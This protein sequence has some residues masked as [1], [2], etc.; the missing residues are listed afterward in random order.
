MEAGPLGFYGYPDDPLLQDLYHL[1]PGS[2]KSREAT[3]VA[4]RLWTERQKPT[5]YLMLTHEAI[6]R[7]LSHIKADGNRDYWRSTTKATTRPV[8]SAG[9]PNMDTQAGSI[10]VGA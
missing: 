8:V 5:L 6:R 2:A 3:R 9:G 7:R 10:R 1:P 4:T